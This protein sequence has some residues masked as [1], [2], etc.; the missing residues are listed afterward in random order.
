V[1]QPPSV[2]GDPRCYHEPELV[3]NIAGEQCLRDRDT[4]VDTDIAPALLLPLV[5]RLLKIFE[6]NFRRGP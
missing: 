3:D 1:E 2:A 4:R 6:N 5:S